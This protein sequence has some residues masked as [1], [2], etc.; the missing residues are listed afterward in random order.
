M[1]ALSRLLGLPLPETAP[2]TQ[3][4][5]QQPHEGFKSLTSLDQ[6]FFSL[7]QEIFALGVLGDVLE[8]LG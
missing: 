6:I 2:R 7:D 4:Q 5:G 1:K 3:Q 8:V